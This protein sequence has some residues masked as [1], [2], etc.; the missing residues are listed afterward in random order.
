MISA[1]FCRLVRVWLFCWR[2]PSPPA[3]R[4]RRRPRGCRALLRA[5]TA[6]AV[7]RVGERAVPRRKVG[8]K[9]PAERGCAARGSRGRGT[10]FPFCLFGL[11]LYY[12][13]LWFLL[14]LLILF[15]FSFPF[16][17]FYFILF[18]VRLFLRVPLAPRGQCGQ[19]PTSLSPGALPPRSG[20]HPPPAPPSYC[21]SP[22]PCPLEKG[23]DPA[24]RPALNTALFAP[25]HLW[26][27]EAFGLCGEVT[28][29][30]RPALF[31][32]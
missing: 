16:Y 19:T 24:Q 9:F 14:L 4:A 28:E 8:R 12:T 5:G 15:F 3:L 27:E 25:W 29:C 1:A 2:W 21:R 7:R 23:T 18:L 11:V 30:K 13:R 20:Q 17:L 6:A 26:A 31:C 10:A 22:R 32:R